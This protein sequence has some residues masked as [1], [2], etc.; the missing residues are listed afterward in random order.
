MVK[1]ADRLA[2]IKA[3]LETNQKKLNL[4]LEE[5]EQFYAAAFRPGLCDPLWEEILRSLDLG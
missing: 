4:Y 2:N 3:S 1:A 5:H